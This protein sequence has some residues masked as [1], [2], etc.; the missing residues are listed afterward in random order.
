MSPRFRT[1]WQ[2]AQNTEVVRVA[3]VQTGRDK[4]VV[5]D[6]KYHGHLEPTL[7]VLE[8]GN[9]RPEYTGL[10]TELAA[11]LRIV[12]FNDLDA[13]EWALGPGDVA[14]VLTEPAMTNAGF[15]LPDP[16]FH[17]GMRELTRRS[18]TLLASTRHTPWS[19]HMAG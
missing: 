5:F 8:D 13:L 2:A 12:P 19:P 9:V 10:P 3:R 1:G 4:I 15:L 7:G 16:G 14:L 6:G 17:D 11:N 18:G